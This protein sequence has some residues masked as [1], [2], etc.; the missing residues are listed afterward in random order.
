M[1]V[2]APKC[3]GMRS[4]V[5]VEWSERE[6]ARSTLSFT[7]GANRDNTSQHFQSDVVCS[8]RLAM[9]PAFQAKVIAKER[10]PEKGIL[11]SL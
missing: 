2:L 5:A 9:D 6:L 1:Q 10:L 8:G 4:E 3:V 7:T 11:A